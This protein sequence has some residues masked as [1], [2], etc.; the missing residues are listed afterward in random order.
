MPKIHYIEAG[1]CQRVKSKIDLEIF[2][3]RKLTFA[4]VIM[5]S[6]AGCKFSFV[7]GS[8]SRDLGLSAYL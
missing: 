6:F 8:Q 7:P 3:I 1:N 5:A 2:S 4:H